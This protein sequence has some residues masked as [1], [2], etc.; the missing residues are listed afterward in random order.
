MRQLQPNALRRGVLYALVGFPCLAVAPVA[1]PDDRDTLTLV[2][3]EAGQELVRWLDSVST[4]DGVP[5]GDGLRLKRVTPNGD[6]WTIELALDGVCLGY[7]RAVVDCESRDGSINNA[8]YPDDTEAAWRLLSE[9]TVDGVPFWTRLFVLASMTA[10]DG[11]VPVEMITLRVNEVQIEWQADGPQPAGAAP[12]PAGAAAMDELL[13]TSEFSWL[14]RLFGREKR[15]SLSLMFLGEESFISSK[16]PAGFRSLGELRRGVENYLL[17]RYRTKHGERGTYV[18]RGITMAQLT[19]KN[20]LNE[21]Y[22]GT[23]QRWE[24]LEVTVL[25]KA[26]GADGLAWTVFVEGKWSEL[27]LSDRLS[28]LAV[29]VRPGRPPADYPHQYLE[30]EEKAYAKT[31]VRELCDYF[32]LE[33]R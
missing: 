20:V 29:S 10:P 18:P 30:A 7:L 19:V 22:Q 11:A 28:S 26:T 14:G 4:T 5:L 6:G 16:F 3:D 13:L 25:A 23:D 17:S 2:G 15:E 21:I 32:Q 1:Q 31:L 12:Q 9:L 27:R 33:C 24:E 8:D